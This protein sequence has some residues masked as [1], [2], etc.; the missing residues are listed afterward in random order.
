MST[1]ITIL[2]VAVCLF[3]MLTVLLQQGKSGMGGAFGGSSAGTV[4]GGAGASSF[5]RR[6][7]AAAATVFMLTSMVLAY[8]ASRDAGEPLERYSKAEAA[9]LKAK[10]EAEKKGLQNAPDADA[11]VGGSEPLQ[12]DIPGVVPETPTGSGAGSAPA[13]GATGASGAGG[14]MVP[15]EVPATGEP[16]APAPAA[17]AAPAPAA[18]AGAGSATR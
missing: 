16:A 2:H 7:T 6:L 3:L 4:F 11:G 12:L 10:K 13:G 9:R 1:L 17:P 5:L 8:L 14:A 18:P 15:A